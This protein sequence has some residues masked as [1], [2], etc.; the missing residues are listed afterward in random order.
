MTSGTNA[1]KMVAREK[2]A[3]EKARETAD[4]AIVFK[5]CVAGCVKDIKGVVLLYP[6]LSKDE[7]AKKAFAVEAKAMIPPGSDGSLIH[8]HYR[9][10]DYYGVAVNPEAPT[11]L[12]DIPTVNDAIWQYKRQGDELLI[13]HVEELRPSS[14]RQSFV[15]EAIRIAKVN[16]IGPQN[17]VG[18]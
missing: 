7:V 5:G 12:A 8:I 3:Q 10:V 9:G 4:P 11:G 13:P 2:A 1:S 18:G 15:R 16:G 14:D 6:G 17:M